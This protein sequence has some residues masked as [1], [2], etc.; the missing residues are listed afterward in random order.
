MSA[1]D[2]LA[3]G[4]AMLGVPLAASERERLMQYVALIEKWNKVYN[5]TAVRGTNDIVIHHLLDSLAVLPHIAGRT[6]LD[7]GSGAGLPGIPLAVARPESR[8]TLLDASQKKAAFL[9][10]AVIEL[11][12]ANAEVVCERIEAWEP[13]GLFDIVISRAFSDLRRFVELASRFCGERGVV[14]AM[15]GLCSPEELDALP[16]Q[17]GRKQVVPLEVPGLNAS[18]HLVL[19]ERMGAPK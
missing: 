17:F 15:K 8:I 13:A 2:T 19:L 6:V 10:Q 5:L 9:R 3:R 7:V 12:L 4:L 1:G 14:A 11:A 16:A 18:R